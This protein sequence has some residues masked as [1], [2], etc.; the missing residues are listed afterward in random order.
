M[1]QKLNNNFDQ[2]LNYHTRNED[3][4]SYE[5][6]LNLFAIPFYFEAPK[7]INLPEIVNH[8]TQFFNQLPVQMNLTRKFL[9]TLKA[10]E[11]FV[12]ENY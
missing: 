5:L 12:Q 2:F 4:V 11:D 9:L 3:W 1:H 10:V 6:H 8:A 7:V